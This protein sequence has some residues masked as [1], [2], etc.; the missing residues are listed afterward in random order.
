M[1]PLHT[2]THHIHVTAL[3]ARTFVD[4]PLRFLSNAVLVFAIDTGIPSKPE[5]FVKAV[6]ERGLF[7]GVYCSVH[8]EDQ[9]PEPVVEVFRDIIWSKRPL[10]MHPIKPGAAVRL[11]TR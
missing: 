2:W 6:V 5:G 7:E 10:A 8:P 11:S 1:P 4:N 3:P 9:I